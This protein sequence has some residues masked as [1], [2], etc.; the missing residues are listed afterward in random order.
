MTTNLVVADESRTEKTI[1]LAVSPSLKSYGL[2]GRARLF[3]VNQKIHE[4]KQ[5]AKKSIDFIIAPP[6]MAR[7]VE[8]SSKI[9]D[10]YLKYVSSDD[11]HVYS[12]DECFIDLTQ[13]LSMYK[14]NARE[15]VK[16]MIQD[17]FKTTGITATAGVGTNLYLCK[18][19]MDVM[20]KHVDPDSDGVRIAE[21][22]EKTYRKKLWN[23]KP[24]TNFW[25]VG[26]GIA[27]RLEKC[28]LN[29][30]RGIYTMG[31]LA[32]ASI[33][34]PDALY[35]MFGINAEILIDHAWGYE[36]CTIAE[37]KK[38]KP[39]N[40]SIGSGQVLSCAYS[41]EKAKIVIQ[42]MADSLALDLVEK[43]LVTDSVTLYVTYDRENVD[44]GK[45][46]G[47]TVVDFYGRIT[48]KPANGTARLLSYTSSSLA[49]VDA[50]MNLA[51][52]IINPE[53]TIKKLNLSANNVLSATQESYDLFSDVEK[54]EREKKM[55]QAALSIKKRFGKNAIFKGMDLQEGATTR[56]RNEQ[57]GG[58]HA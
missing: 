55:Q 42:E 48:P 13:Y 8:F 24:I 4:I 36:P 3:E 5:K 9:Y 20:A 45:Y 51:Y 30:G 38:Y 23:H 12:I 52:R 19:A 37:I 17:V 29:N 10:V 40:N 46:N 18:I 22:D 31:D 41:F 57:I 11:I 56:E 44:N 53:L 54:I 39:K 16:E 25:Q 35:K 6:Q 43:E 58:H 7:Y 33:K 34:N 14:K 15:L 26:R 1:C 49:I 21:L 50:V 2:P 47:E 28:Y 27:A 32:R